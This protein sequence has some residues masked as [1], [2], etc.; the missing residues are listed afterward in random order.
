LLLLLL[1]L[2]LPPPPPPPLLLLLLGAASARR[3]DDTTIITSR[4]PYR[5]TRITGE[6]HAPRERAIERNV[7]A[8]LAQTP[9]V[10][11]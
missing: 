8:K 7:R 5:A 4:T 9:S 3:R 1:P 10:V 6:V 2:L 11:R